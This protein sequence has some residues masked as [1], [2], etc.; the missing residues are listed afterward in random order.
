[1]LQYFQRHQSENPGFFYAIQMDV[2]G[3]LAN[4]FW[5]DA[6]SRIAYKNFGEVVVLILHI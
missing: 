1:M 3:H 6:R 4:C 2:D 5:V